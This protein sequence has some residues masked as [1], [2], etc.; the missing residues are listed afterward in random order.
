MWVD[1]MSGFPEKY[2]KLIDQQTWDFINRTK[3][4]YPTDATEH[5]V[6]EQRRT[7]DEMC[8]DFHAG[9]PDSVTAI[10]SIIE[11]A[12]AAIPIRKYTK[13]GSNPAAHILYFHGGGFVLGGLE[14]H[15]DVCAEFCNTANCAVTSVDYRLAPEHSHP[16]AFEDCLAA[17][18]HLV[19]STS[20]P[21]IMAGDSAGA[22]LAACVTHAA[23]S[24][25]VRPVGQL[26]IYPVIGRDLS[27][28]SY[29][30]H[31]HAPMLSRADVEYYHEIRGL[32]NDL[33]STREALSDSDFT[34]LPPTVIFSAECDPLASDAEVYCRQLSDA[35]I[36]VVWFDEKG[37]VH[38]YL[39]ARHCADRARQSFARMNEA[40]INLAN[41]T[42]PY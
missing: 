24:R 23:R 18:D 30:E 34:G 41:G 5:S 7:Y 4:W 28:P 9:Y 13:L 11:S 29:E 3:S 22:S 37:L 14:S 2:D 25:H 38:G 8:R 12:K 19:A 42:W 33:D 39:R 21:V 20:L 16:A 32:G 27:L 36:K 6:E 10:D 40:L 17:Y 35:G 1:K 31:S 15:D 26:L